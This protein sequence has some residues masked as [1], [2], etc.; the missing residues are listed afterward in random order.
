MA[1]SSIT[2]V[3]NRGDIAGGE[4]ML[5]RMVRGWRDSGIDDVRHRRLSLG[6]GIVIWGRRGHG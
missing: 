6:G 2:F 1:I 4:L 3:A 5:L